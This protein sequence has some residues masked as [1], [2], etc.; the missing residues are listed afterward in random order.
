MRRAFC[1][2]AHA[3][4]AKRIE[5]KV[6]NSAMY[7]IAG[8]SKCLEIEVAERL[9]RDLAAIRN[10]PKQQAMLPSYDAMDAEVLA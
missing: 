1:R 8:A 4:L 9:S 10:A 7:A 2:L 5:P 3:V 6:A